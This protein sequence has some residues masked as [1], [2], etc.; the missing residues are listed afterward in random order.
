MRTGQLGETIAEIRHSAVEPAG[1]SAPAP[2][3]A[4]GSPR[5]GRRR[6]WPLRSCRSPHRRIPAVHGQR[7]AHIA[8]DGVDRLRLIRRGFKWETV[9]EQ[10]ILF[11]VVFKGKT[12][13]PPRA[14]RRYPAAR[15]PRRVLSQPLFVAPGSRHRRPA[16]AGGRFLP[17]RRRS[18]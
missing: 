4:C 15:P 6:A 11:A 3:L 17:P 14:G 1:W 13:F 7:L 10:L 5:R 8:E 18:G 9:A 12:C 2:P 16:C